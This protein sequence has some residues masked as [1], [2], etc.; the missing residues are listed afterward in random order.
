MLKYR[1][2]SIVKENI[3]K[4]KCIQEWD[5]FEK[6]KIY[7]VALDTENVSKLN[8]WFVFTNKAELFYFGGGFGRWV[9]DHKFCFEVVNS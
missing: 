3:M 6:D 2:L 9:S 4:V 5:V 8:S 1:I 7:D